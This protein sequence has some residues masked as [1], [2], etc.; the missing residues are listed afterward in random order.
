[1]S[2]RPHALPST[3]S[4]YHYYHYYSHYY[5]YYYYYYDYY[6]YYDYHYYYYY[7]CCGW[8][9]SCTAFKICY[10]ASP[11]APFLTLP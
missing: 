10:A 7:Y 1:M 4:Y 6:D 2:S 3:A 8:R 5:H 11:R 9:K